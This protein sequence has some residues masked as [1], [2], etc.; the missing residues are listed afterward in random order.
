MSSSA[1]APDDDPSRQREA[2]LSEREALTRREA[3]LTRREALLTAR[4]PHAAPILS[5][6]GNCPTCGGVP[7]QGGNCP[8]WGGTA[9]SAP[10]TSYVYAIGRIEP[11]FPRV[12]IEKE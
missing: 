9:A 1:G 11:R 10:F 5:Q 8:T 4:H 12:S 6:A 7:S 2:L 3:L